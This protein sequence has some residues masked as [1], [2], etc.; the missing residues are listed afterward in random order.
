MACVLPCCAH[1]SANQSLV[2]QMGVSLS[3]ASF[4]STITSNH[5]FHWPIQS[6]TSAD[7]LMRADAFFLYAAEA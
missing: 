3:T 4:L 2:S 7:V 6:E 1:S 5:L